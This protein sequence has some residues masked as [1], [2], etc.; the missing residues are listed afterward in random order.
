MLLKIR[1][2]DFLGRGVLT[3][4]IRTTVPHHQKHFLLTLYNP[5]VT[6]CW[7]KYVKS[8][9]WGE[10]F[11]TRSSYM[12]HK[13]YHPMRNIFHLHHIPLKSL[14][15][16]LNTQKC[17]FEREVLREEFWKS[18]ELIRD[19]RIVY[20][21]IYHFFQKMLLRAGGRGL[22]DFCFKRLMPSTYLY[23]MCTLP[24]DMRLLESVT[25]TS[26]RTKVSR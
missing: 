14:F 19:P 8:D 15:G 11:F 1:K 10:E 23:T 17:F 20:R 21:F 22:F 2:I 5:K 24:S 4:F 26:L 13:N 18:S 16:S 12:V 7:S 9:F 6:L 3:W 25:L